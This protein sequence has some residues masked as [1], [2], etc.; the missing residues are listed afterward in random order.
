MPICRPSVCILGEVFVQIVAHFYSSRLF[1]VHDFLT[2]APPSLPSTPQPCSEIQKALRIERMTCFFKEKHLSPVSLLSP[3][4]F[5]YTC[6]HLRRC[7]YLSDRLYFPRSPRS[8]RQR[9]LSAPSDSGE[10]LLSL[11]CSHIL[12]SYA[13]RSLTSAAHLLHAAC[14]VPLVTACFNGTHRE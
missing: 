10:E 2:T 1:L 6:R 12:R 4:S 3:L 13:S 14:R 7:V 8:T 5:S 11:T 9:C